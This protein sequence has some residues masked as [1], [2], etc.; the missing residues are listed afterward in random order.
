MDSERRAQ[1][2]ENLSN[3]T[4]EEWTQEWREDL[5]PEELD[6]VAQE[7]D[8]YCDI[9]QAA[10]TSLLIKDRVRQQFQPIEI[11]ELTD[12]YDHCR[13]RLR[14]GRIFLVRLARDGSL[15]LREID[16]AC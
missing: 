2:L 11:E 1:I 15:I 8:R 9:V 3:E 13:L 16:G 6:F 12:I 7:D 5:T 14:D 4:E 10:C